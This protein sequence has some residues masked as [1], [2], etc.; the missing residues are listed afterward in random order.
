MNCE[1]WSGLQARDSMQKADECC[2]L[3]TLTGSHLYVWTASRVSS[4]VKAQSDSWMAIKERAACDFMA[5][6][7]INLTRKIQKQCTRVIEGQKKLG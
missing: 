1:N 3:Q 7:Y 6:L 4:I 5:G 2:P